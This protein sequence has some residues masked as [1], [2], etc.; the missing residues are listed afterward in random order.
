[1]ENET[2]NFFSQKHIFNDKRIWNLS[3][4]T[5]KYKFLKL[6]IIKIINFKKSVTFSP[7]TTFKQ[8]RSEKGDGLKAN[9]ANSAKAINI[10][11]L[12]LL[13]FLVF[14]F[15]LVFHTKFA[16]MLALAT[17]THTHTH[18]PY[19]ISSDVVNSSLAICINTLSTLLC[20]LICE[21]R[22]FLRWLKWKREKI[23]L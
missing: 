5:Q 16:H 2:L 20:R 14:I 4:D 7:N 15:T 21:L 19:Q 9:I 18:G 10:K 11:R 6:L 17:D 23:A 1:M 3:F 22:R 13:I 8:K 12:F